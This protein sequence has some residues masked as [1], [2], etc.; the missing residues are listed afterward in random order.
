MKYIVKI[1]FFT[2]CILLASCKKYEDGP[3]FSLMSKK[4]RLANIWTVDTYYL[5]G[6][7]K[8]QQYRNIVTRDKLIIFQSGAFEY[9]EVSSWLWGMNYNGKW[10][11][12][13]DKEELLL[14]PENSPVK[15]RTLKILRLK[16]KSI[17]LE[18]RISPDSLVEYHFLPYSE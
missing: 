1:A 7:D 5:N 11:F 4:A 17:W 16:N 8:T 12:E 15:P 2:L 18:E 3:A 9:S 10:N 13:N 6:L 14:T